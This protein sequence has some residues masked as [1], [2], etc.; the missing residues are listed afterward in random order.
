MPAWAVSRA[1]LVNFQTED[2]DGMCLLH[3]SWTITPLTP[4]EPWIACS[5]CGGPRPF[6]C[7]GRVRLNANGRKLDAWLIYKCQACDRTWNRPIF[8]RRAVRDI[9]P[10]VLTALH[11]NDPGWIRAAAFDIEALRR[12][13]ARVDEGGAVAVDKAVVADPGDFTALEIALTVA[14]PTPLRL[15]RLLATELRLSRSRVE[16]LRDDGRLR[17][18]A[19]DDDAL[20]RRI[21]TGTRIRIDLAG[22]DDGRALWRAVAAG[23]PL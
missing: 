18:A 6:R 16:R 22:D 13:A 14:L 21:R 2:Q 9:D 5:T 3:V 7:S 19:G 20:R 11:G 8:E 12:R 15:D 1:I 10:A 17:L 23:A 4:P